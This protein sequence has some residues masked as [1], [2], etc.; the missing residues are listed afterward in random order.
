MNPK[1]LKA[2][3][4][5]VLSHAAYDPRKL[6]AVHTGAALLFS[7]ILSVLNFLL[8]RSIDSAAGLSQLGNR[9]ILSTAQT[10]LSFTGSL[11]LPFWEVGFIAA[12]LRNVRNGDAAPGDLFTGFRRAGSVARLYLLQFA[13]Y[14]AIAFVSVQLATTV[15]SLTP[16]WQDTMM[17]LEG[18]I[19]NAIAAGQT[20]LSDADMAAILPK[21]LP[22]YAIAGVLMLCATVPVFYLLR[23]A[24]YALLDDT[25]GAFAAMKK[26]FLIMRKN[27]ITLFRL[28]LHFWWFYAAQL[29]IAAVAYLDLILP[30]LGVQL[31]VSQDALFFITY[32]VHLVLQLLLALR[33]ASL[34]QTSYAVCYDRWKTAALPKQKDVSLPEDI[35]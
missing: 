16:F 13:L 19:E 10:V 34:V 23:M 25:P 8:T 28:D 35:L 7:L 24:F 6:A 32:G 30:A 33:F 29:L 14:L 11:L 5:D 31:P 2:T 9:A 20:T 17:E 27:C 21:L 12:A 15:F 26:S 1:T 3:A 18:V 4:A 22:I